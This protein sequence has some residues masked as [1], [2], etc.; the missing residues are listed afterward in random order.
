MSSIDSVIKIL[1]G[2]S[3]ASLVGVAIGAYIVGQ[4]VYNLFLHPLAHVPGPWLGRFSSL[5]LHV[6][7]FFGVESSWTENCHRKFK[8][9]VLRVAPN[10]ISISDPAALQPI[11]VDGGGFLKDDR[12]ENFK[13]QGHT[14]IFSALDNSYRDLRAKSVLPMVSAAAVRAESNRAEGSMR[15]CIDEWID[16]F[17]RERER[18]TKFKTSID[19]LDLS[20]K[21]A[22]DAVTA[23]FFSKRYGSLQEHRDSAA[24]IGASS[25]Q[26][27]R[28]LSLAPFIYSI[29]D[30]GKFSL[31]PNW[32]FLHC[33]SLQQWIGRIRADE[34]VGHAFANVEKFAHDLVDDLD[35]TTS[36]TTY[37]SRLMSIGISKSEIVAQC[38]AVVFAGTD[39]TATKLATLIF[40]LVQ[41]PQV[42]ERLAQELD[43]QPG[44]VDLQTL[45]YLRAVIREGLRLGMANPSRFTRLVPQQGLFVDGIHIPAGTVVGMAPYTLHHDPQV[46]QDP[47]SFTPEQWLEED[48]TKRRE[49][50]RNLIPFGSGKRACLAQNFAQQE[51]FLAVAALIQAKVLDGART[52]LPT[53]VLDE[54][55]NVGIRGHHLDITYTK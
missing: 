47:F 8:T 27:P 35:A 49:R 11:Y 31:L 36:D 12:Y 23:F 52:V 25:P 37:Q 51:L 39:S 30:F 2:S 13:V 3:L 41:N 29:V 6:L 50:E 24:S 32:L 44:V 18:A 34:S 17:L 10:A 9:R 33:F 55:F 46:Y 53:I 20:Q 22:C 38:K 40:H 26:Q 5:G 42:R 14:T 45:P 21:L 48:A 7:N 54:Y 19:I 1:Q 15:Q 16:I 4:V 28:K 43:G